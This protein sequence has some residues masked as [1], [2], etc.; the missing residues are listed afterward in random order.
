MNSITAFSLSKQG[1]D[2]SHSDEHTAKAIASVPTPFFRTRAPR[3]S[4]L[5]SQGVRCITTALLITVYTMSCS[6]QE[7][8]MRFARFESGDIVGYGIVEGDRLRLIDGDLFGEWSRT[9]RTFA[10][11]N[12]KL[13][14][15]TRP[16][17]VIALAGNYHSHLAGGEQQ[18]V[19][20]QFRIPQPF[21]KGPGCLTPTDT[22][23]VI[24]RES[25]TVHFEAELVIVIGAKARNVPQ[26]RALDYV[27]GATC[28]N[29]VSARVWQRNDVQWWR[30]KGAATFGPC[31]PYI[32]TGLDYD[33]LLAQL[34]LNDR[35]MQ[36]EN[37]SHMIND[38][39][40]TVS[41]ISRHITLQP[42]DL[43]Y[44]G[45]SGKTAAI[46]PGDVVEVEIEGIG[47]L[48]NTVVAESGSH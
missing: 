39:A 16:A 14:V 31:G 48:R 34:R 23:I 8:P 43:I 40:T 19:P 11:E 3:I 30:A 29:D 38:V 2:F 10:I 47:T 5:M 17:Q 7:A 24:P 28:G 26:S 22:N 25:E 15:P 41:F 12:V 1:T 21:F 9:D 6:A 42:G 45:T 37:T 32:A 44:T 36:K 4:A 46:R 20:E 27:F 33:N 18:E 13:L 35:V